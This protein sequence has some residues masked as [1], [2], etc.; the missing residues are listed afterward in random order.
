MRIP[1][2]NVGNIEDNAGPNLGADYDM[3]YVIRG[4]VG[5]NPTILA[6]YRADGGSTTALNL[7]NGIYPLPSNMGTAVWDEF[8]STAGPAAFGGVTMEGN[9]SNDVVIDHGMGVI[10]QTINNGQPNTFVAR[11]RN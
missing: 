7:N 11:P 4:S 10:N 3:W 1:M 2:R 6:E 8:L 9:W 5:G